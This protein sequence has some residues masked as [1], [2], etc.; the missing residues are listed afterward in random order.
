MITRPAG[1]SQWCLA[2]SAL[3]HG[4]VSEEASAGSHDLQLLS[5]QA[6]WNA[7]ASF[8]P[9]CALKVYP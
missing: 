6:D 5:K 3:S 1:G 4:K 2:G 8:D 7:S 9:Q